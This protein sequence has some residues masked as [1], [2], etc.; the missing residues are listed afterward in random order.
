MLESNFMDFEVGL[1]DYSIHRKDRQDRRGEGV[2]LALH[3]DLMSIRKR[4]LEIDEN[5]E[6]VMV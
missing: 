5:I 1:N 6:T 3:M 2:L 4:D